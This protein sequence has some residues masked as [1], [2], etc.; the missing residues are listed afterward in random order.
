VTGEERCVVSPIPG[1]T[2]DPVDE[3]FLWKM[4]GREVPITLIGTHAYIA[5]FV[6]VSDSVFVFVFIVIVTVSAFRDIIFMTTFLLLHLN[7]NFSLEF[8]F[9]FLICQTL[10]E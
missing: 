9:L 4:D 6:F 1:T 5:W 2:T 8:V 3:H 7:I 10:P